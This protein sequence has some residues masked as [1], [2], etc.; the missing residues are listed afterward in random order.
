[1]A[2]IELPA[3]GTKNRKP[4]HY[5]PRIDMTPMVDLGFLLI[6]FFIFTTTLTDPKTLRLIMPDD[7]GPATE[8]KEGKVLTVLL[9]DAHAVYAYEGKFE[10]ALKNNNIRTS[11]YD[12]SEG[13]GK[14]IRD[15]QALLQLNDEKEGR[16]G[17]VLLIKPA[18][19]ASYKNVIDALDE[20]TINGV[21]KYM[22][23]DPAI[24]ERIFLQSRRLAH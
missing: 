17:L 15:K 10:H 1:M 23:V 6:A 12:E 9:D 24:E 18:S 21:K 13:I 8:L 3:R 20:T 11:S 14:M 2:Q 19:G 4:G 7:T 5:I 16:D 22:V